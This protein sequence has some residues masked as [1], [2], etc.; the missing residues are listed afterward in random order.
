MNIE[1]FS[2]KI[3]PYV[4]RSV[5]LLKEKNIDFKITYVPLYPSP[6]WFLK[7]SPMGKVPVL[8]VDDTVLFES[9]IINEYLDETHPPRLL[10]DDPLQKA[11]SRAW[12]E[13]ASNLNIIN[14]QTIIAKSE[15]EYREK[16]NELHQQLLQLQ[17]QL[18]AGP[19]FNGENFSLVDAAFAPAFYH[20]STIHRFTAQEYLQ[21]LP[22]LD[23]WQQLLLERPSVQQ[24]VAEDFDDFY[25]DYLQENQAYLC[26]LM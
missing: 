5:I 1:L 11:H 15:K 24:S 2:F 13:F 21:D 10:P 18:G 20:M 25:K 22:G 23:R 7:I 12:I 14:Y 9:A 16:R 3:C 17:N 4:Q 19:Y 26:Q 6:D 8:K